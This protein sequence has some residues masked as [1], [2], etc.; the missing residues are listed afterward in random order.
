[1]FQTG[2]RIA[3]R[4][5]VE[6]LLGEGGLAQVYRVRH[7][8]LGTIHALK[9]L[10][11]SHQS[12][13]ERLLQ[14]GRIQ[15]Q[16]R[17]P[18]IIGVSDVITVR[19]MPGLLLEYVDCE[20]LEASLARRGRM[21]LE[22]ALD[23]FAAVL[24][25]VA[26]AHQAGVLH[27]DLK[28]ANILLARTPTG[29]VPK[30]SDFGIAKI[31]AG[32]SHPGLT[33]AGSAMGTPGYV[34]PE[35]M[36]DASNVDRRADVFS[37]G[38]ILY[39]LV[40][41]TRAFPSKSMRE[42][43][44][45]AASGQYTPPEQVIPEL[46][47]SIST[48]IKKALAPEP[49]DRFQ[50]CEAFAE[51][52]FVDQPGRLT[53]IKD[54]S[55]APT[56]APGTLWGRSGAWTPTP[57]EGARGATWQGDHGRSSETLAPHTVEISA[58]ARV[59]RM[60]NAPPLAR[61]LILIGL[62]G[63]AFIGLLVI[64]LVIGRLIKN[65]GFSSPSAEPDV[66][67]GAMEPTEAPAETTTTPPT[68][69]APSEA[70][71]DVGT[72]GSEPP[73]TTEKVATTPATTSKSATGTGSSKATTGA[74]TSGSA[75]TAGDAVWPPAAPS[76]TGETEPA[77]ST[78]TDTPTEAEPTEPEVARLVGTWA[79][80]PWRITILDQ[81][82][83]QVGGYI[84]RGSTGTRIEV[85]GTYDPATGSLTL[86]DQGPARWRLTGTIDGRWWRGTYT[87]GQGEIDTPFS[88]RR[89]R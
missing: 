39:E 83:T 23:L 22:E 19:G 72:P 68:A 34:A 41:G 36:E 67:I 4:F 43:L 61:W 50:D 75:A 89:T 59:S 30:V 20:T 74:K 10:T 77:A 42:T 52:L 47:G 31:A 80:E 79:G 44:N 24:S 15:A 73:A 54:R 60:S 14:E 57:S 9:L 64:G 53:L 26:T 7:T 38:T 6:A 8:T 66:P 70:T 65:G 88:A 45:A 25:G 29:I 55:G 13:V 3:E 48:T 76:T 85:E 11:M 82:G 1:M 18:N 35:Q 51:S 33:R 69:E 84:Y 71:P 58:S 78:T 5:E 12:L 32:D 21:P 2:E 87:Q 16:L 49:E 40:T 86:L 62:S 27:R 63:L 17:H 56:P 37:L 81:D 46:P 28:P